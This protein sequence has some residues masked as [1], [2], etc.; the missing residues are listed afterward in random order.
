MLE[1]AGIP[2]GVVNLVLG[3]GEEV[4]DPIVDHPDVPLITF[5]GCNGIGRRCRGPR[6]ARKNK[7]V[8]LEMGGKNAVIVMD[9][10]DLDLAVEGILWSAFGT[11]GQRCTAASRVV[12]HR[13]VQEEL[14]SGWPPA[15]EDALGNGLDAP[16][17]SAR[18]SAT[19][20]WNRSTP[21]SSIGRER[22]RPARHRRQDRRRW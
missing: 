17:T 3:G 9:D 20:S 6:G 13:A 15:L 12:V 10:A 14:P 16:S 11:S 1:E 18:S 22:R 2:A 19:A 21:T 5:T 8:S 4:G 7:R